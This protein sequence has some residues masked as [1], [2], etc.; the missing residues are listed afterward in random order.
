MV[1]TILIVDDE[2]SIRSSLGG[3]LEDEGYKVITASDGHE[4]LKAM[5]DVGL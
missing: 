2:P 3:V 4:A 5:E 1:E